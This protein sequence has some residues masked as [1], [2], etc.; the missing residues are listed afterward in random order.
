MSQLYQLQ[1]RRIIAAPQ[2]AH[3]TALSRTTIWR[4]VRAGN[5]P[6]PIKLTP[7][8]IGWFLDEIEAFLSSRL[9]IRPAL[10]EA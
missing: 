1:I 4:A 8:R 5:F 9:R 10:V 2:V 6:A 3:L 7:G